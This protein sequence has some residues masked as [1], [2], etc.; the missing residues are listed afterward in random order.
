[1]IKIYG[2]YGSPF[3]RKVLVLLEIKRVPY[4]L[5]AQMPFARDENYQKLNALPSVPELA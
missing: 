2:V 5:V 1:M 3:V 4:E